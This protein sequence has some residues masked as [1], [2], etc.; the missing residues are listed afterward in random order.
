MRAVLGIDIGGTFTDA[1]AVTDDGRVLSTKTPSTPPDYGR[2][3]LNTVDALAKLLEM[4]AE[5][6]LAAT[7]YIC[8]GTTSTLNALV[9]GDVAKVGFVTTRGHGDS[10]VIMNV[11]GRYAGLDPERV[12]DILRTAKPDPLVPRS[13]LREVVERIDYNGDVVVELDED[14]ARAVA[15]ELVDDGVDALAVS[16]LWSFRNSAHEDRFRE[17]VAE[18]SPAPNAALP[19]H[20]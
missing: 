10:I 16:F 8:H 1:C 17:I 3:V 5:E 15:H 12:Q 18:T 6:L 20:N 13:R 7:A 11:E 9:T 19:P 4:S 14:Q 2:G